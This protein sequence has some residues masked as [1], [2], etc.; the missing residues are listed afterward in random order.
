M[1]ILNLTSMLYYSA[2]AMP[3]LSLSFH[4]CIPQSR[5]TVSALCR[6]TKH[7]FHMQYPSLAFVEIPEMIVPFPLAEC[8]AAV[9]ARVWSG[10][11]ALPTQV[12]MEEWREGVMRERGNG[13]KFHALMPPIDLEYMKEM[14]SWSEG[15]D[16]RL[17]GAGDGGKGK[18]P[19][20]WD[21]R[22]CWLRMNAAEMKKAFNARGDDR[23]EVCRYETFRLSLQ[24]HALGRL[25]DGGIHSQAHS[26]FQNDAP[27]S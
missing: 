12:D 16:G 13:R 1:E 20:Y 18:L 17:S 24:W 23:V 27:H 9:I 21:E 4:K 3:T 15:A 26:L 5:R 14:Y 2:P 11:L 19:R 10:R 7:I 6:F 25:L 8:Q 22:A